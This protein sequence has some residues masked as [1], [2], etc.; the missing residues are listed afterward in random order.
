[1]WDS[2]EIRLLVKDA[3]IVVRFQTT[4][5]QHCQQFS[6]VTLAL[7]WHD[8]TGRFS[9]VPTHNPLPY[10][11][12]VLLTLPAEPLRESKRE[13][14]RSVLRGKH[15]E[16]IRSRS[17]LK[18]SAEVTTP[19]RSA[20]R[21]CKGYRICCVN[22]V[23]FSHTHTS[24]NNSSVSEIC[25]HRKIPPWTHSHALIY[26]RDA[27]ALR[28][29]QPRWAFNSDGWKNAGSK[30]LEKWMSVNK[31]KASPASRTGERS[32]VLPDRCCDFPW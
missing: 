13:R 21:R 3:L 4:F 26:Y 25:A 15:C 19:A 24:I 12:W 2:W 31:R 23:M 7:A 14:E 11:S 10:G 28:E 8:N 18:I 32:A 29:R 16:W 1:M 30:V 20:V 6:P 9:G 5:T 22:Q 27:D 17:K